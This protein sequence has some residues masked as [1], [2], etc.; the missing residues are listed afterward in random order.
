[1]VDESFLGKLAQ[2]DIDALIAAGR[3]RRIAARARL[4]EEGDAAYEVLVVDHGAVKLAR[5]S[6]EGREVVVAVRREGAILGELS[7]IDGGARS[8]SATTLVAT[9]LIAVPFNNF[10]DLLAERATIGR[11]L[12]DLLAQRLRESTDRMLE[13]GTADALTRVCRR[14][15]EFADALELQPADGVELIVPLTQ[16]EIAS[17]S[18]LS[19]EAVVKALKSLREL[20]WIE[21]TGRNLTLLDVDAL[22]GRAIG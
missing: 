11:A 22:R 8:T 19:R 5:V 1:M 10:R 2:D 15:V 20:G 12:L 3:R 6:G 7:A 14:L 13:F 9:E 16:Q 4:F 18:G 17:L 21:V